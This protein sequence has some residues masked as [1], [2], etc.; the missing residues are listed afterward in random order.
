[1]PF[2]WWSGSIHLIACEMF[3]NAESQA[4]PCPQLTWFHMWRASLSSFHPHAAHRSHDGDTWHAF[5]STF[6]TRE[7]VQTGQLQG[8]G[9]QE[10]NKLK[11]RASENQKVTTTPRP[12]GTKKRSP[13]L[14][15]AVGE[16]PWQ[17][18]GWFIFYFSKLIYLFTGCPGSSSLYG[19]SLVAVC[20]LL[21]EGAS[22]VVG[23]QF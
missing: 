18:L 22:L 3:R 11:W 4:L 19:F 5:S 15:E 8:A 20:R 14:P 13:S 21:I 6:C 12:E 23:F 10:T 7:V 1:M 17:G 16:S 9:G 2:P